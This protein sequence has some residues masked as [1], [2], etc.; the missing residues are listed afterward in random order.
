MARGFLSGLIWGGVASV[1]VVGAVSLIM[2]LPLPPQVGDSA[3]GSGPVPA[4][5]RLSDVTKQDQ[6]PETPPP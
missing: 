3:P 1:G 2:P 6:L 4:H 5:I